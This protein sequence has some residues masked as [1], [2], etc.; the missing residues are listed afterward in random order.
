MKS[1]W[2]FPFEITGEQKIFMPRTA[3]I[4]SVQVQHGTPCIWALVDTDE[5][6]T[7]RTFIV[8]GT[9]HPCSCDASEFIGTFQISGGALVF[10]LF[11][12]KDV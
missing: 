10:H 1:I 8:H 12:K 7:E 6:K 5:Q 3:K 9:G 11:E 4:L 2:K